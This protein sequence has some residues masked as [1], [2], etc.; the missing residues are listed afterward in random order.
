MDFS[1]TD[2]EQSFR[3]ELRAWLQANVPRGPLP[4][5][6]EDEA[7]FLTSW[8]RKLFDAGWAAVHWPPIS[9]WVLVTLSPLRVSC[10]AEQGNRRPAPARTHR[11]CSATPAQACRDNSR[12]FL[13]NHSV[14]L[15]GPRITRRM[16]VHHR[17]Q[18]QRVAH[19][20]GPHKSSQG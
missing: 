3:A 2:E 12:S 16:R 5:A 20:D 19:G 17:G 13:D 4:A 18:N 15:D 9:N 8:Q 7:A 10:R 6:L 14:W 1:Y 11:V